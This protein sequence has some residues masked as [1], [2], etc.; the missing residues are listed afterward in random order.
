MRGQDAFRQAFRAHG[1]V[2][3]PGLVPAAL[4]DALVAAWAAEVAPHE[5][6]LKRQHNLRDEPH[7]R[8]A[9]GFVVNPLLNAHTLAAF[10]TF[11]ALA[12]EIAALDA[13]RISAEWALDAPVTLLQTAFFE[14]S[15]GTTPHRDAP[16]F[17]ADGA[18]VGAWVALEDVVLEAGPFL[19]WPGTRELDDPELDRLAY[20][21]RGALATPGRDFANEAAAYFSRLNVHIEG[22]QAA[23]CPIP[24]G[25][26]LWWDARIIHGSA[27]P[28]FGAGRSR[29]SLI[30]HYFPT[31]DAPGTIRALSGEAPGA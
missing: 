5:G 27:A 28:T 9:D 2:H 3:T 23:L 1:L 11:A 24:K 21:V 10:P 6:P 25:D 16:P 13:L 12:A 14:S 29:R 22:R 4:C 31:A 30:A 19:A 17:A 7:V 8:S 18:M 20:T 15:L 26:V